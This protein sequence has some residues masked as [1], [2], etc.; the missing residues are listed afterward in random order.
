M[1]QRPEIREAR[2]RLQQ[3]TLDKRA[4]KSEF[5]P[6]V[7]LT[8]NYVATFN[9]SNFVPR[10]VS[11]VGI[12]VEWEVFDWG[13]QEERGSGEEPHGDSSR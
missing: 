7:S 6:D 11:G 13:P 9:Y 2:L 10:S 3:A 1:D 12:Q 5:I 8:Y 4:K